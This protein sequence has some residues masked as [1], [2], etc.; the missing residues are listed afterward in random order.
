MN[1]LRILVP[2]VDDVGGIRHQE[3][4]SG[5]V[6]PVL[7]EPGV[8]SSLSSLI[9][10]LKHRLTTGPAARALRMERQSRL[11]TLSGADESGRP[12]LG[13]TQMAKEPSSLPDM[14]R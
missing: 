3:G 1:E 5:R 2:V 13:L 8:D 11:A 4:P 10:V 6:Y 7:C 12:D 9:D 14:S